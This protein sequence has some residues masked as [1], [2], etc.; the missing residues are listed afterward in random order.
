MKNLFKLLFKRVVIVSLLLL[1][2]VGIFYLFLSR[3][4]E[5][6]PWYNAFATMLALALAFYIVSTRGDP[7]YKIA[8]IIPVLIAPLFGAMLYLMLGNAPHPRRYN[9]N[10]RRIT[11]MME[12]NLKQDRNI[13]DRLSLEN[14]TAA[15]QAHYL[16]TNAS[17][18]VYV[19]TATEYFPSGESCYEHMLE[20]MRRAKRY[21][22]LEYFIIQ[23]GEMWDGMLEILKEKAAQGVDVRVIYDDFGC[24]TKL[25]YRYFEKLQR[26]GIRCRA[27]NPFIPIISPH[28]NNR[29]HRKFLIID[30]SVG[31][32]GGVNLSDEY[33]NRTH[34]YGYWKDCVLRMDGDAV[35]SMTIMFLSMWDTIRKGPPHDLLPPAAEL[36]EERGYVQPFTDCPLDNEYVSET[37]F[38]N[39]IARA[40]KSVYIMTPYLILNSTMRSVLCV[41]AK[42]GIDVRIIT[43]GI[44][45][46]KYVFSVTRANYRELLEAGVRIYEFT[47]GFIHSKVI[48]VDMEC[49]VV[50]TIN[51]DFRS[52]YLH[53]EDGVFLYN[54][55]SVQQVSDDFADTLPHCHEVTLREYRERSFR[56][57]LIETVL[58]VFAPMM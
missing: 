30:G 51:M 32:T 31:Y 4:V 28:L 7:A 6:F 25:P 47:P 11:R 15:T 27:F 24:I 8:W 57:R 14:S 37:V 54:T 21:I 38:L 41:A 45:D 29:D 1:G 46:K 2:Q 52:L 12:L 39:M 35:W 19:N 3:F 13:I 49:A 26:L 22:Y 34:P 9:R 33:I 50:G 56:V 5:Y 53:F 44:P 36:H 55:N 43:P 48:C 20:D 17:C 10:V 16:S 42:S 18:P 23:P 40:Q 58:R